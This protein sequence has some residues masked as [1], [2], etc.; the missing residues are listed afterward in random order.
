MIIGE[1]FQHLLKEKL[2]LLLK[3]LCGTGR[4]VFR[5]GVGACI[6]TSERVELIEYVTL[7][8]RWAGLRVGE[9]ITVEFTAMGSIRTNVRT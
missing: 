7:T 1:V 4:I 9:S 2:L 3:R 6:R 8:A 5:T